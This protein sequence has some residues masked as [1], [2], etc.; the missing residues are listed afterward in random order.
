[1]AKLHNVEDALYSIRRGAAVT[2]HLRISH[3]RYLHGEAVI[4]STYRLPDGR[5]DK[6]P[7]SR[8][9][10][11]NARSE[12]ITELWDKLFDAVLIARQYQVTDI[13][14]NFH[15]DT[16]DDWDQEFLTACTIVAYELKV[17]V[18]GVLMPNSLVQSGK[19]HN[20]S[21]DLSRMLF[22]TE[23]KL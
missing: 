23:D 22:K 9:F 4:E 11:G 19:V 7:T 3:S 6:A 15:R 18:S 8:I 2:I 21:D 10:L 13:I 12:V 5:F 1:M 20:L 17:P 14:I 16:L